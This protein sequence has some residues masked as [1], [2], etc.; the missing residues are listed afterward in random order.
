MWPRAQA[1]GQGLRSLV[2]AATAKPGPRRLRSQLLERAP[3]WPRAQASGQT[4]RSLVLAATAMAG[5]SAGEALRHGREACPLG[6]RA[7]SSR[8]RSAVL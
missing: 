2:L 7:Y 3:M 8:L 6:A 5:P 1:S 4:L